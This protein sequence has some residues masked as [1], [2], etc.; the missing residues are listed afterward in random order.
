V[1]AM[2]RR[3]QIRGEALRKNES[4]GENANGHD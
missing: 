1:M 2:V 3:R 4:F